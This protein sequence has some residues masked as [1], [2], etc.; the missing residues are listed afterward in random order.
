MSL[1]FVLL[2]VVVG[3]SLFGMVYYVARLRLERA[4]TLEELPDSVIQVNLLDNEDGV[5]VAEGRGRLVFANPKARNWF[6]LDGGEPD[7][8]L[9]AM[10]VQPTDTFMELFSREGHAS[11]RIGTRRIEATSHY[12]PRLETTQMVVVMRELASVAYER[13][14]LDPVRAM[15][16]I[17]KIAEVISSG[18][19]L[20]ETLEAILTKINEV[21]PFD[22]GEITLWDQDLR[23]L[24]PRGRSGDSS[25]FEHFDSTDG[26][27]HLDD[28][29]SGWIARY[30][31]PLLIA[32]VQLRPDVQHKLKSYPMRS[33]V[34]VPLLVGA[35][36]IGTLELGSRRRVAF[37]HED[38]AFLQTVAGQSGIAID[39]ARLIQNQTER[40]AELSG[41]Q[42]IA[43][44]MTSIRDQR[45]MYAQ[46]TSRI[47]GLMNVEMCGILLFD[48][49]QQALVGIPP[50]HG[51]P[52]AIVSMYRIPIPD[53]SAAQTIYASREW[54]YSNSVRMD[55]L[56]Q[57]TGLLS[58]AEAVGVRTTALVNMVVGE[59]RL[60]V[61]QVSNK[62][63][64]SGFSENDMRL[65]TVF[66]SQAGIVV[67]N[68]RLFEEEQRRAEELGGLQQITQAIGALTAP[69]ELYSQINERIAKLMNVQMCGV[70]LFDEEQN[71]LV[72]RPPFFGVDNDLIRYYQIP[73]LQGSAFYKLYTEDRYWIS[74]ELRSDP[75]VRDSGLDKLV[76]LTGVRQTMMVPLIISGKRIG[77]VQVSNRLDGHDFTDD[78]ARVL[79]I[80]AG[81]AAVIIDNARLYRQMRQQA[82]ESESLSSISELL[83][84]AI[85]I[86]EMMSK[87]G[88]EMV[89]LL[90][91][92]LYTASLLDEQTGELI[93]RPEWTHGMSGLTEPLIVD[94]YTPGYQT[95]VLISRRP[96]LTNN[97]RGD[98]RVFPSYRAVAERFNFN[99]VMQ[100]PLVVQ[101]R[102]VGELSVGAR[103][104]RVFTLDDMRVLRTV[105]LQLSA[106]I[107]RQR[108]QQ[109]TDPVLRARVMELDA[110]TR[111]ANELNRT[112][113]LDRIL[114]VTRVETERV[115]DAEGT[116]FALL[117]P[118]ETWPDPETP[119]LDRRIGATSYIQGLAPIEIQAIKT[120]A[121][122][123]ISDYTRASDMAAMPEVARNA[124]AAPIMFN[125]QPVGVVHIYDPHANKF[126]AQ[127]EEFLRT[128]LN[129]VT[130]AFA[131]ETRYREQL[132]RA[133]MLKQ[134]NEQLAQIFELGGMLRG[135]EKLED[136]L[137]AVAHGVTET[138]GFN[139]VVISIVDR[140][141]RVTRRVA[142]AGLP[143]TVWEE[144]KRQSPPLSFLEV[145]MIDRFKIS[146]SY[147]VP[148]EALAELDQNI[149]FIPNPLEPVQPGGNNPWRQEDAL[150]VPLRGPN[151]ELIGLMSVDAPRDGRRPS[152]RTIEAL[153]IFANQA[154]FAIENFQLVNAYQGEAVAAR[155]ERDRLEQLYLIAA[156]IQRAQDIPTRLRVV[157]DGI[158]A[159]GW[160]RVAIT[161]RDANFEPLETITSG[162]SADEEKAFRANLLS[163]V[164]WGQRLAD[165]EFRRYRI[166]Q[167]YY[168]RYDSPWL[169][170]NKLIAGLI[171]G[172]E[173]QTP[174]P[175]PKLT[176]DGVWNPLDV[177]YI[178]LYG[179]DRS[180]LIGIIS[181]DSPGDNKIPNETTMRPIELLANQAA[182]ALEN[183]R[184]NQQTIAAAQQEAQISEIME[185]VSAT[186]ELDE[187][188]KGI[189]SGFQQM[190]PFTRLSFAL[191]N[192]GR[193]T[194]DVLRAQVDMRGEVSILQADPLPVEG[195]ALG[196]AVQTSVPKVYHLMDEE[197]VG[198][199]VDL[200]TWRDGGERT[201]LI[202]PMVAGGRIVG[203]LHMGSE[204]AN[205]YGFE[206]QLPLVSR[207]ANLTAVGIEN[208]QLFQQTIE[209]EKFSSA[210]SRVSQSV[211]ARLDMSSVLDTVCEESINILNVS[212][213][214]IWIVQGDYLVGWAAR[215]PGSD[216]FRGIRIPQAEIDPVEM[217]TIRD[218]TPQY[219]NLS[220]KPTQ[221]WYE[222]ITTRILPGVAIR[223]LLSVPL[224]R[225]DRVMGTLLFVRTEDAVGFN[226]DD[227]EK[228]S[229]FAL[230]ASVAIGNAQLYQ[231]TLALQS[232]NNSVIQSIQQ[233]IV[234]VDRDLRIR[235]VNDFMR[236]AY[237]WYD[238]AMG[239]YLYDYRPNYAEFLSASVLRT[240][241]TGVP[242]IRYD[243]RDADERGNPI[244]RNFYCYPLLERDS[245]SGIVILVEDV[246]TRASLEADVARR[247]Q[248]LAVL[249]ETSSQLTAVL[250][251]ESVV[252]VVFDQLDR[253]LSYDSATLWLRE[254][255][256]L[257]IR[258]A[259]GY[260]DASSLIGIKADIADSALFREIAS[261]GQVLNIPD[262]TQDERFPAG[263]ELRPTRTWLGISLVSR[264]KLAGLL[265]L[266][267]AEIGFYSST[268][269]QLALTF[270]NQVA[271]ALE[272]ANLFQTALQ[273]ADEN[274]QLY[275]ETASRARDLDQQSRRLS[276]LYRVSNDLN[277]S[278]ALEDVFEVALRESTGML[279]VD[280]G[281]AYLYEPEFQVT[282]L[283]IEYP[284][285]DF[286]PDER[287]VVPMGSNPI[288]EELRK[289]MQPIAIP[290]AVND[291]RAAALMT[292][293]TVGQVV[294]ALVVPLTLGG[295]FLGLLVYSSTNE[296]RDFTSEQVEVAQ[297]ITSQAAIAVQNANLLEQSLTRTRELETLFEATQTISSTLDLKEVTH[298]IATQMLV[299]L[300][301]DMATILNLDNKT[302]E[303]SVIEDIAQERG[304]SNNGVGHTYTL[305][306]YP[307]RQ[308]ALQSNKPVTIRATDPDLT[309]VER[310]SLQSRGT[311]S[312]MILPTSV[313]DQATGLIEID[314]KNPGRTFTVTEVRLGRTLA[315]QAA[316]ALENATLQNETSS[317]L[318]E[319]FVMNEV[320]TALAAAI[321][322]EA[323]FKVV[324]Q[325]IPTLVKAQWI[326]MGVKREDGETITY[327]LALNRGKS[328]KLSERRIGKDEVSFVMQDTL[329]QTLVGAE[330]TGAMKARGYKLTFTKAQALLG[331]PLVTGNTII[332]ALVAIDE[333]NPHAFDLNDQ[334]VL[335][336]VGAQIAVSIQNAYL[337]AQSRRFTAELEQA[338]EQ[339]TVE[340]E[341]EKD[342]VDFLYKLTSNLTSSLDIDATLNR[343]L[344]MLLETLDAQMGAIL[345]ADAISGA[346]IHRAGVNVPFEVGEQMGFNQNEGVAGWVL[347]TRQPL[348][349][350][351]IQD[352]YR[353]LRLRPWDDEPR[354]LIAALLEAADESMGVIMIMDRRENHF[355]DD[356]M[357]VLTAA[358]KQIASAMNNADLYNLIKEQAERLSVMIRREQVDSTKNLAIVESIA[359]GVMVASQTG[360]ITQF[361]SAA[362]RILGISRRNVVGTQISSLGGLYGAVGGQNWLDAIQRWTADPTLHQPG[363]ELRTQLELDNG[364]FISVIL[365][366][367]TMGDQ[368]LGTVSVFRD[369]TRDVEVDRMKSEFVATVSHELRTPMTSIKGY[370]D[371]LLLGAA[372]QITE[373]QQRFLSTI[374]TNADRLSVLVNELLDISR[375]DRG[376]IKL[377][378]QPTNLED[379]VEISL[380]HLRERIA[381][382]KKPI[383][384]VQDIPNDLPLMRADFDKLAQII[385]HLLNNAY[386]Y[387]H[388]GGEVR[389]SA[390][391]DE[392]SVVISV[393]DQGIG[394]A[395]EKQDKIWTRFFRDEDE[396][397]VMESSGAGL[398]L[399]IVKEYV[400]MHEGEIWL[401][402]D[403]GKGAT[404]FV[405]IPAF[406]NTD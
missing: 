175:M 167:G 324:R 347:Q 145:L 290:D 359:D 48:A 3:V 143:I 343:A 1:G 119:V 165:P 187:I 15:D 181:M 148:A 239:Q 141:Q 286:P 52:D 58:L 139:I 89:R 92:D 203:A 329:P 219:V 251:P 129:Q 287:N 189:A 206:S 99:A 337:F 158:R 285:S 364:K 47:A 282:R 317:R 256:Q 82:A 64:G 404:F 254:D 403:T 134:R 91:C 398:G 194:F 170:E 193:E 255:D 378:L 62:R 370:A 389:I 291:R 204:L 358:S 344:E 360:E 106:A 121:T 39:N 320:S 171:E 23:I 86:E 195:T 259:R 32:D 365:S 249:T 279:G 273:T 374:K 72:S 113:E 280:R 395:K 382:E 356:Q 316:V 177:V 355:N 104:D 292:L 4:N 383:E 56:V 161:L 362:E 366:P 339:R 315:S 229:T 375:I 95:S 392:R 156:E 354:S 368:F 223:A 66:A 346:L 12:I 169:T 385:N 18:Q 311:F 137:E 253:I 379:V 293:S 34:G 390:R 31:Q 30:T 399:S 336:T 6:N 332:G 29:F 246:T 250:D 388:P 299:A 262:I 117:T 319:V 265:V 268:M 182:N 380:R 274:K 68:A 70:L 98:S 116:T 244:V 20:E 25:Y 61:L 222:M 149:P 245:V 59:H 101:E 213:A 136:I 37:D 230:Q 269:E 183:T 301:A 178:P 157:A 325:Q 179:L 5:V 218:H 212:G 338:V 257:V 367:V 393:A 312:R 125:E 200:K 69:D 349:S 217:A 78:D 57:Q 295:Q 264:G 9:M 168:L 225:E 184:L 60:G 309:D 186:L 127:T 227:I 76:M 97:I 331:V 123:T 54:W 272:N 248:Q 96:F 93:T 352:D 232:F 150:L 210:L 271:V 342:S 191:I 140:V 313:R 94:T 260:A 124:I 372:G 153:E 88:P 192:S 243:V 190:I 87:L 44:V 84:G 224:L 152:L 128:L 67:E 105:A 261:R 228:A 100:V 118:M 314:N 281:S 131:N 40:S 298:N 202:T 180:R 241:Q 387:S 242:E 297:T 27:Y 166:G 335:S 373:Q 159:A 135:G 226:D 51:V 7:L 348:M 90:N 36:F 103:T 173:G 115:T 252:T 327:P 41:L 310:E 111:I 79:S 144:R 198:D 110:V 231:E 120:R 283:V 302:G 13:E 333:D 396:T 321:D 405:R 201:S 132:E 19:R 216:N 85:P 126:T 303:L 220:D 376:S 81:Q 401:E 26:I 276:L 197:Q 176:A 215:G 384:L 345:G 361:N 162:Y 21:I 109:R 205:A 65:L 188:V 73:L 221:P 330:V 75:I 46:M 263:S 147:F 42:L 341:R 284:R 326:I 237:G 163:G 155:R 49:D 83:S 142:Q 130:L 8:E 55:D 16:A 351:N 146:G 267:K 236:R 208:A 172:A 328:V 22:V 350:G 305:D 306:Q 50:F 377:N 233:G 154:A 402:S 289:T 308:R 275:Q 307:A 102:G 74:N 397:L 63:D 164:V 108:L 11:F 71:Q 334:R 238:D 266:E 43:G 24:R 53:G 357:R 207:I 174:V 185:T 323:I 14:S 369:V 77:V 391:A 288:V 300:Q 151:D 199:F 35:R 107:E 394:I 371:L 406:V 133:D 112:T 138:V 386:S 209:R 400:Q 10:A 235:T 234:V 38:M 294:S 277:Q 45:Q 258:G 247:A 211:S 322:P 33:F 114:E 17:S 122:V 240:L 2:L 353:W 304:A 80:F 214:Y 270:A 363:E 381:A 318:S 340:L 28:S 160:G 296:S 278:F 196:L